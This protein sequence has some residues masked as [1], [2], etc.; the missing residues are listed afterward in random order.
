M[1]VSYFAQRSETF[2]LGT[3][4]TLGA[5][6]YLQTSRNYCP[7]NRGQ[8]ILWI[9]FEMNRGVSGHAKRRIGHWQRGSDTVSGAVDGHVNE[10]HL[11]VP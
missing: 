10:T 7:R 6:G 5:C 4:A 11:F 1:R 3:I 8:S 9:R 2:R